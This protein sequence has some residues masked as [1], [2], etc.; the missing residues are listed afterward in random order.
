MHKHQKMIFAPTSKWQLTRAYEAEPSHRHAQ[1]SLQGR[2]SASLHSNK[3]LVRGCSFRLSCDGHDFWRLI[4]NLIFQL[5][6]QL[7]PGPFWLPLLC[8]N[9][10]FVRVPCGHRSTGA[11]SQLALAV[12]LNTCTG[13][14]K[15]PKL[16]VNNNV[17]RLGFVPLHV[18]WKF[19]KIHGFQHDISGFL[20]WN[21]F[22]MMPVQ[23]EKGQFLTAAALQRPRLWADHARC[24]HGHCFSI[25]GSFKIIQVS[26]NHSLWDFRDFH[27]HRLMIILTR[28]LEDLSLSSPQLNSD[29]Q[30]TFKPQ[31]LWQLHVPGSLQNLPT[32]QEMLLETAE[33]FAKRT[34]KKHFFPTK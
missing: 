5:S 17:L 24:R 34:T 32:S 18:P 25:S 14:L 7:R 12:F 23:W 4:F 27:C 31:Y 1:R 21:P 30:K 6:I 20:K 26:P 22:C 9:S 15:L 2:A 33:Q 13:K 28:T 29:G 10:N 19:R 3:S 8:T 16:Q 11:G